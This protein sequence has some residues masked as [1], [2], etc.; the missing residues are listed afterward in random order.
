MAQTGGKESASPAA[1]TIA[2]VHFERNTTD[3][4]FEVVFEAKGGTEG[5]TK[6][7]VVSPDGRTVVDFSSP[8]ASTLGM[9]QF[10]CESPEPENMESVRS[11]FPE[12]VYTF[13]GS[14]ATGVKLHGKA[15]LNH[16]VAETTSFLRPKAGAKRVSI[17]NL[18]ISW[19]PVKNVAAYIIYLEQDESDI[20]IT[21]TLRGTAN[22]FAVP[23]GFLL[24]DTE[25]TLGIG[26][27]TSEGNTSLIETTF[28][29]AE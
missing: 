26:T 3:G 1:F 20:N 4:D 12:G 9:R 28:T 16:K 15:T 8:D 17:K 14:T 5:L 27:V 29:T 23:D 6:F 25:Y 13:S 7:T 22:T 2:R 11:A 19:T 21:A 18:E 24:P 10:R